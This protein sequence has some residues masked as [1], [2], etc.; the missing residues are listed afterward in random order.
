MLEGRNIPFTCVNAS[1]K[2]AE[3][4][5]GACGKKIRRGGIGRQ[6]KMYGCD[7]GQGCNNLKHRFEPTKVGGER[8]RGGDGARRGREKERSNDRK[9]IIEKTPRSRRASFHLAIFP[10]DP[11]DIRERRHNAIT[12][13]SMRESRQVT[14]SVGCILRSLNPST[15]MSIRSRVFPLTS[16][17]YCPVAQM[18]NWSVFVQRSI[19]PFNL[20]LITLAR[21]ILSPFII[22][23]DNVKMISNFLHNFPIND[24]GE[25]EILFQRNNPLIQGKLG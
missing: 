12:M 4:V 18:Q 22:V 21:P 15:G 24:F 13:N 14:Q 25:I 20:E 6:M 8:S 16:Q 1:H 3:A 9:L 10:L 2:N 7:A 11:R 23:S 19:N 17:A 5:R